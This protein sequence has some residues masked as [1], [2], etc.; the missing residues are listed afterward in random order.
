MWT[1]TLHSKKSNTK[2]KHENSYV[3]TRCIRNIGLMH[4]WS[5]AQFILMSNGVD[6]EPDPDKLHH[7]DAVSSDFDWYP[8]FSLFWK[9]TFHVLRLSGT[10]PEG[11]VTGP[12]RPF[13]SWKQWRG[14]RNQLAVCLC[15]VPSGEQRAKQFHFETLRNVPF[16]AKFNTMEEK[17]RSSGFKRPDKFR[18]FFLKH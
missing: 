10:N 11:S 7:Q 2:S 16:A 13:I 1:P 12:S 8:K 17:C 14:W 5:P 3:K 15:K 6:R 9:W 4:L 18:K